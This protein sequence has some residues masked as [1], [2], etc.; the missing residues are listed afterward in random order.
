MA[1]K[2][3][4]YQLNRRLDGPQTWTGRFGEEK[5]ILPLPGFKFQTV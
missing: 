4:Q 5:I 2:E 3:L 1:K